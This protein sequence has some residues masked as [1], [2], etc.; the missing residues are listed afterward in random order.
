M[1]S[2]SRAD[3]TAAPGAGRGDRGPERAEA[4]AV[5]PPLYPLQRIMDTEQHDQSHSV[6]DWRRVAPIVHEWEQRTMAGLCCLATY[7][8]LSL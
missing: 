8:H 1:A 4:T 2:A 3:A 7:F 6:A 5:Q